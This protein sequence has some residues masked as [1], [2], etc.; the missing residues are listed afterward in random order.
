[1]GIASL[2][3]RRVND[4]FGNHRPIIYGLYSGA[5][6]LLTLSLIPKEFAYVYLVP[7][8]ILLGLSMGL[9]LPTANNLG[10]S[11]LSSKSSGIGSGILE[12]SQQF[13]LVFGIA[14]LGAVQ[15][16]ATLRGDQTFVTD[17]AL[18]LGAALALL[19]A[20]SLTSGLRNLAT[21][22]H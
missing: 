15:A 6:G 21:F 10:L 12:A 8:L 19:C 22:A 2:L 16:T 14:I 9:T 17:L 13:G 4:K 5:I 20:L 1:M 18:L 11:C 7:S 3:T